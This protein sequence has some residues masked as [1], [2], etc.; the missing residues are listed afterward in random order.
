MP[1][2]LCIQDPLTTCQ[3]ACTV[4]NQQ[5]RL[6]RVLC[7]QGI[8]QFLLVQCIQRAG[9][10][11]HQADIRI[12]EKHPRNADTLTLSAGKPRAH[13]PH[14]GV[15]S[16]RQRVDKLRNSSPLCCRTDLIHTSFRLRDADVLCN[17]R[18]KQVGILFQE[19]DTLMQ[20]RK[21][22]LLH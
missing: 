5:Q 21:A 6:S 22:D 11:V 15:I 18:V 7:L 4:R 14:I 1:E 12:S 16:I 9:R 10:L 13:L 3:R 17:R 8:Q 2:C 19:R 20:F